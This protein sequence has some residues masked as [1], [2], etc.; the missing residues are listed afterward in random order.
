MHA[1]LA[2]QRHRPLSPPFLSRLKK[3][4]RLASTFIPANISSTP[5]FISSENLAH[6]LLQ[7][8][9]YQTLKEALT[10]VNTQ[11]TCSVFRKEV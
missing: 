10:R 1:E 3:T 4:S 5:T 7:N 11:L 2:I 6:A 8:E 9:T